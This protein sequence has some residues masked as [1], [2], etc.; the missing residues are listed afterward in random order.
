MASQAATQQKPL[1]RVDL[2]PLLTKLWPMNAKVSPKEIAEAISYFFTNQVSE[3][4]TASL[5][6]SL[7]F[8]RLDFQ[9]DVLAECALALRQ[10]AERIPVEE[11]QAVIAQKN[12]AEGNY[13]GGLVR[14][15]VRALH[16]VSILIM[17]IGSVILLA[18]EV[19]HTTPSISA[20]LH[21]LLPRRFSWSPS[22]ATGR[23]RPSRA[24]PT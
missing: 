2:K 23:A 21:P 13:R 4:Q 7:H 12:K 14:F 10:A 16:R 24:V 1:P 11:L 19:T 3:A 5:L 22:M 6:M 17:S 8:T 9:G 20:Q 15:H 18:P